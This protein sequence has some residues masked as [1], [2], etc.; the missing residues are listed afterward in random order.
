MGD[1][2]R[3]ARR[4]GVAGPDIADKTYSILIHQPTWLFCCRPTTTTMITLLGREMKTP[5]STVVNV[6][7]RNQQVGK[8]L[9]LDLKDWEIVQAG[10]RVPIRHGVRYPQSPSHSRSH[11]KCP[12]R[13]SGVQITPRH[14]DLTAHFIRFVVAVLHLRK[15]LRVERL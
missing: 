12:V 8:R 6:N 11:G 1:S 15:R 2:R 4:T 3:R 10:R 5:P 9:L 14:S 7:Q 13:R